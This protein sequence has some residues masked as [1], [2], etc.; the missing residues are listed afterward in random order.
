MMVGLY[1]L[2]GLSNL[3][4][5]VILMTQDARVTGSSD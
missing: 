2:S 3:N 4:A 5:S 1:N